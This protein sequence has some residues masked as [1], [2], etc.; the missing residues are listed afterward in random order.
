[1]LE[2]YEVC[3]GLFHGFDY[4]QT[5]LTSQTR[6]TQLVAAQEHILSQE[7]GKPRLLRAVTDLG[8]AFALAVP[9]AETFR[10]R[11]DVGFFQTVRAVLAKGVP[12][13]RKTDEEME[14]AIRQ[15]ISGAL[16]ADEVIDI[17]AAA[18]LKKPDIS[19]LSDEFLAEVQ[20]M[21]QRTWRWNCCRSCSRARLRPVA[22]ATW[23]RP[24]PSLTCWN[25]RCASTRT[26]P[27]RPPR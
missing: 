14:H 19:I 25:S 26:G 22:S 8:Q 9:H 24:A 5:G 21:P 20:G 2:K 4:C 1:M 17:F 10:I 23:C 7:E 11:D 16:V 6:L 13:E 15:V 3:L 27:S 12:G 18:G